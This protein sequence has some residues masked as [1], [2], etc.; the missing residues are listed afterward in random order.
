MSD[1]RPFHL[2]AR[3]ARDYD[4]GPIRQQATQRLVGFS[5]HDNVV[6]SGQG[7]KTLKVFWQ[8]PRQGV[9]DAYDTVVSQC[10]NQRK[11]HAKRPPRLLWMDVGRNSLK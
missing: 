10:H 4:R 2:I 7:A 1:Q 9:I 3:V 6:A 11:R 5:S 8:M